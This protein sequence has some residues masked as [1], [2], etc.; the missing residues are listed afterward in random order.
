L[1]RRG[2]PAAGEP[3]ADAAPGVSARVLAPAVH[4][5]EPELVALVAGAPD[6][7]GGVGVHRRR[8]PDPR[9]AR[10][11]ER[12]PVLQDAP[13][14]RTPARPTV[15]AEAVARRAGRAVR[16]PVP[17]GGLVPVALLDGLGGDDV[18]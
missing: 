14:L 8:V 9:P 2:V 11:L 3:A 6:R 4:F 18:L 7:V 15:G 17:H 10:L 5:V 1:G 12:I 16:A 13:A